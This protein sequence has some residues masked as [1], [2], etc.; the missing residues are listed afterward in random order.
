[1]G[2]MTKWMMGICLLAGSA[3]A[4]KTAKQPETATAYSFSVRVR[5]KYCHAARLDA[6]LVKESEQEKPYAGQRLYILKNGNR[7]TLSITTTATGGFTRTLTPGVYRIYFPEKFD[8]KA[9]SPS[10]RCK[11]WLLA[12]DTTLVLDGTQT[13]VPLRLFR[14]CSPCNPIRQ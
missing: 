11:D 7:D 10:Q 3:L 12:P 9:L 1:M 4:C 2:Y 5:E 8:G 6:Q 13:D 14:G